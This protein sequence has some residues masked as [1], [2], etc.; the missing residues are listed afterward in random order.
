MEEAQGPG[1]NDVPLDSTTKIVRAVEELALASPGC[2]C[3]LKITSPDGSS[4]A[5]LFDRDAPNLWR[6]QPARAKPARKRAERKR[7]GAARGKRTA[8]R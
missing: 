5:F 2:R 3:T 4:V 7:A 6:E 1:E 8:K